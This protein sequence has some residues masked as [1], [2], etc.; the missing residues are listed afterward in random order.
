MKA[1]WEAIIEQK[2]FDR[3]KKILE[4]NRRRFKPNEFK[5]YAYPFSGLAVCGECG[6]KLNGKSAH[7][8]TKK[9]HYYDHG[10]TLKG[11]GT[12][13]KH[14]CQIQRLRAEKVEKIIVNSLKEI[15]ADP[16]I[17]KFAVA[18]YQKNSNKFSPEWKNQISATAKEITALKKRESN[19]VTRVSDLPPDVDASLFYKSI[20]DIQTQVADRERIK[21][22]LES[23]QNTHAASQNLTTDHVMAR[24]QHAISQLENATK[25]DQKAVFENVIQFAKFHPTKVRI[26]VMCGGLDSKNFIGSST[27]I[28]NG[29]EG[30]KF[31][32]PTISG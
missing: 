17:T 21:I 7:G 14:H 16:K 22:T 1:Q 26:G 10:R 18:A 29:G 2:V 13:H 4:N 3:V 32:Q 5:T 19:L 30:R 25:E 9:H 28:K 8:K 11:N 15:L 31:F 23:K 20:R 24:V 27:T 6:G 12:G